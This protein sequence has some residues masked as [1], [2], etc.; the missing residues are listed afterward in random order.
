[1]IQGTVRIS[2][3]I[4]VFLTCELWWLLRFINLYWTLKDCFIYFWIMLVRWVFCASFFVFWYCGLYFVMGNSPLASRW[5]PNFWNIV[6]TRSKFMSTTYSTPTANV[7][8]SMWEQQ[9][10]PRSS[11]M[12]EFGSF[13][14]D[15]GKLNLK[16]IYNHP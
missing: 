5:Q 3:S 10:T 11:S 16:T 7:T 12:L 13:L 15:F 9:V 14:K 1:M 2:I 8:S 4:W 6:P